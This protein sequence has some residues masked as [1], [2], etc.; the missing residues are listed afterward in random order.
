MKTTEKMNPEIAAEI[1]ALMCRVETV[2]AC[3]TGS[4]YAVKRENGQYYA[5]NGKTRQFSPVSVTRYIRVY[6][7]LVTVKDEINAPMYEKALVVKSGLT[8]VLASE[9]ANHTN[10]TKICIDSG[11]DACNRVNRREIIL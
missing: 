2:G 3:I 4:R 6:D 10:I 5:Y 1:A 7:D 9:I 8:P 11:I